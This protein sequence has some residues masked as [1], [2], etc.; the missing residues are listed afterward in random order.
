M[1][2]EH[3]F[4]QNIF[5]GLLRL[6]LLMCIPKTT[7]QSHL[8]LRALA[9]NTQCLQ[10]WQRSIEYSAGDS[11]D[12][13]CRIAAAAQLCRTLAALT[14]IDAPAG[15]DGESVQSAVGVR[16][17]TQQPMNARYP[18]CLGDRRM[19]REDG[20]NGRASKGFPSCP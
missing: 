6:R 18:I 16:S 4:C 17:I 3:F 13:A 8:K 1:F 2:R 7:F 9:S 5:F 20:K 11:I 12:I 14:V 10:W 15:L 19:M